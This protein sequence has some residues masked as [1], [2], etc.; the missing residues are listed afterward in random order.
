[1]IRDLHFNRV[2]SQSVFGFTEGFATWVMAVTCSSAVLP[3]DRKSLVAIAEAAV[4]PAR[5]S[6]K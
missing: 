1:M 2:V 6:D 4:R 5:E 3:L